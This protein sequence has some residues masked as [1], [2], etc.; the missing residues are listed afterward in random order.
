M[1]APQS[2]SALDELD[3]AKTILFVC[4]IQEKFAA[5]I[6]N[7]DQLVSNTKKLVAG[8]HLLRVPLVVTEQYPRGLGH[9]VPQLGLA[10]CKPLLT[11]EKTQFNMLTPEV[12]AVLDERFP[13]G[14]SVVL[15]GVETHVCVQQ[16]ALSLRRRGHSVYVAQ[17]C[18]SSRTPHDRRAALRRLASA[19]CHVTTYEAVLF[20]LLG[21]K[22]HPVFKPLSLLVREKSEGL[23]H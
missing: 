21:S 14:C 12:T 13:D 18:C 9:T 23:G 15:C 17:D 22:D 5:A 2:S 8:C 16:T 19:G 20:E 6:L 7:F 4:D 11:A 1:A 3:P 10:E